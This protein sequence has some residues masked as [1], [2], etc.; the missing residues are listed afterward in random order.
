MRTPIL[1]LLLA[2]TGWS[3]SCSRGERGHGGR[4]VLVIAIDALRVDHLGVAGYDRPTTPALDALADEGAFFSQ[5]FSAAPESIPAHAALLSGC[6]PILARRPP[7]ADGMYGVL[8]R[9]WHVPVELPSLARAYLAEGYATAAFVDHPWLS[10]QLGL[11]HGFERFYGFSEG[12]EPDQGPS[13]LE[14]GSRR[15]LRWLRGLDEDRDWFA[16]ITVDELQGDWGGRDPI[17]ST[18][19]EAR[20]ELDQVPPVA[21]SSR[22]FFAVPRSAWSGGAHTIG[23]YEARYDGRLRRLDEGLRAL[24]G[25]LSAMR[26]LQDTTIC[27]VGTFGIGFGEAGLV[28]DHGTL[29]DVDLHVP[30]ILRPAQGLSG[31]RGV[32]VEDLASSIDVAPTLLALSGMAVPDGMHGLAQL[33]AW[34]GDAPPVRE[35]AFA[36]GGIHE[37]FAV[38]SA[39]YNY[40]LVRPGAAGPQPLDRTFFGDRRPSRRQLRAHLLDRR[41]GGGPG[42]LG[43]SLQLPDV[44]ERMR[45]AGEEWSLWTELARDALHRVPWISEPIDAGNVIELEARGLIPK[46][47]VLP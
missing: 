32:V 10:T 12:L 46:G 39:R 34:R 37:G 38:R 4:G 1:L 13:G 5:T 42:D 29:A 2:L 7:L 15:L 44:A 36:R 43:P 35:Y 27:V 47:A 41:A 30:W 28:L 8:P 31:P 14:A 9:L 3:A 16:Y 22:A 19:F 24:F 21:S 17:W 33:E 18:Y 25:R 23:E 26:R 6:D 20:P 45:L 11:D 40:E